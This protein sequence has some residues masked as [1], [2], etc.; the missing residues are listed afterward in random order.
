MQKTRTSKDQ[1]IVCEAYWYKTF[2]DQHLNR[3]QIS[4]IYRY[5]SESLIHSIK[6][7]FICNFT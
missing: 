7:N 1:G 5:L 2:N 6:D 3:V 4:F